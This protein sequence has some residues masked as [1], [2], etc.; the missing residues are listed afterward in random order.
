MSACR[1]AVCGARILWAAT[2][3]TPQKPSGARMPLD[4]DPN[5]A[6]NVVLRDG[7]AHVLGKDEKPAA[8]ETVFM[9]HFA[10]CP[11]RKAFA[12]RAG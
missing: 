1:A 3:P 11:A 8:D 9:P 12:R 6:G 2:P 5:P 7:Y 10:T 4:P